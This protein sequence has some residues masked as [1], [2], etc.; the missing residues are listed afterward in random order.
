MSDIHLPARR[1]RAATEEAPPLRI[2]LI[3]G[4]LAAADQQS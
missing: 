1:F 4:R 2:A 3:L